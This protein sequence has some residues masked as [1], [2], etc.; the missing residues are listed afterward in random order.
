MK[1]RVT[2]R[3]RRARTSAVSEQ[4]LWDILG[5]VTNKP[6]FALLGGSWQG[7]GYDLRLYANINRI[8][9]LAGGRVPST[10]ARNA[11]CTQQC[12]QCQQCP[13]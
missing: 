8:T 2:V 13:D 3:E 7:Y 11:V 1:M 9:R 5:K 12:Q 6:V 10:F 4:A